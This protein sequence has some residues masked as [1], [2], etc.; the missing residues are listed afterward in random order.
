MRKILKYFRKNWIRLGFETLVVV[1][2]I[3]GAYSL[4]NWNE[5]RKSVI[6]ENEALHKLKYD[7]EYDILM[8]KNLDSVYGAWENQADH[9][10]KGLYDGSKDKINAIDEYI[11]GR[12]S[13]NY[14]TLRKITYEEMINTGLFYKVRDQ[15]LSESIVEYYEFA[16]FEIEKLNKDNRDFYGYL[17]MTFDANTISR[18]FNQKNLEYIDWNWLK[19]PKSDRYKEFENRISWFGATLLANRLV[20][21]QLTEKAQIAIKKINDHQL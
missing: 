14:L 7:L 10:L 20:I 15:E 17:L 11:V 4:N 13:M 19:D 21:K 5:G 12:N 18:L 6:A 8:F 2:G 9:I 3:L 1:V 16:N